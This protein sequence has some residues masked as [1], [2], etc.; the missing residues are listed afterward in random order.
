MQARGLGA[1]VC[2]HITCAHTKPGH[3]FSAILRAMFQIWVFFLFAFSIFIFKPPTTSCFN[4]DTKP[5]EVEIV[6][7]TDKDK[8]KHQMNVA[9]TN[10]LG[11]PWQACEMT[12]ACRCDLA[13]KKCDEQQGLVETL[14]G[15]LKQCE[16]FIVPKWHKKEDCFQL[17]I[18]PKCAPQ[19]EASKRQMVPFSHVKTR[20]NTSTR[21]DISIMLIISLMQ[22][23]LDATAKFWSR[24]LGGGIQVSSV[25][26]KLFGD[27]DTKSWIEKN[28]AVVLGTMVP[29]NVGTRSKSPK[30]CI[31][32]FI[33][34]SFAQHPMIQTAQWLPS[35]VLRR[36]KTIN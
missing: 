10:C 22:S 31:D 7:A 28:A 36:E 30:A 4:F 32:L 13:W 19:P 8:V 1:L 9:A 23:S 24:S 3:F 29:P 5:D 14:G 6:P 25:I 35:K 18:H 11:S 33:P 12:R 21:A 16:T 27:F 15:L 17:Q 20:T 2:A 34:F 26:A